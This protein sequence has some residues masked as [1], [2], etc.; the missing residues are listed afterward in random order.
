MCWRALRSNPVKLSTEETCA[1]DSSDGHQ[2]DTRAL[3]NYG[4]IP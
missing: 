2:V 1:T 3:G 4:D